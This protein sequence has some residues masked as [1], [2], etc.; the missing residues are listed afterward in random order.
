MDEPWKSVTKDHIISFHLCAMFRIGKS[1]ETEGR[2]VVAKGRGWVG[3][4]SS[5]KGRNGG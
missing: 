4:G 2:L 5:R 1:L 3:S